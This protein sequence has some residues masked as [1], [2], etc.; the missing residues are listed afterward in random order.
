[1]R[2]SQISHRVPKFFARGYIQSKHIAYVENNLGDFFGGS[3]SIDGQRALVGAFEY[4]ITRGF[5]D[6]YVQLFEKIGGQWKYISTLKPNDGNVNRFFGASVS[7]SGNRALIGAIKADGFNAGSGA[8]YVFELQNGLWQQTAKLTANDGA[9]ND[10]FGVSV[11][12]LENRALIGASGDDDK[13]DKSGAAYIFDLVNNTW[14]QSAKVTANDGQANREFGSTTS[15]LGNR[16]LINNY[17]F[18]RINDTWEEK[19]KLTTNDGGS[20]GWASSLD[21]DRIAI[22]APGSVYIFDYVNSEWKESA[23]I[24][25]DGAGVNNWF[26]VSVSLDNDRVLIGSGA[27][28]NHVNI[29]TAYIFELIND[30]WQKKGEIPGCL[31]GLL[32]IIDLPYLKGDCPVSLSGDTGLMGSA[33][34]SE[35]A[36]RA[37]AVYVLNITHRRLGGVVR[38]LPAGGS[39]VLQNQG[40]SDLTVTTTDGSE[41]PFTFNTLPN[42]GDQY[43]VTAVVPANAAFACNVTNGTG[44]V[45]GTDIDNIVVTCSANTVTSGLPFSDGFE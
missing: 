29:G 37:G 21:E 33:F 22:S 8:A 39:V 32:D 13:G 25:I 12:L 43:T 41:V 31:T 6:G 36:D 5:A 30:K 3:L 2:F 45:N 1:M 35:R 26:G 28:Y 27:I 16:A 34:D 18:E 14:I 44:T 4:P 38:G 42:D 24:N 40:G 7:L 17:V 23:K 11:S 10:F 9:L 20:I 19:D 15:I